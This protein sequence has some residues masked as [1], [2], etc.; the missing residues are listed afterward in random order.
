[1]AIRTILVQLDDGKAAPARVDVAAMLA[2][3]H[4]ARLTGLCVVEEPLVASGAI[5]LVPPAALA[6]ARRGASDRAREAIERLSEV[7]RCAGIEMAC[8]T[9]TLV[10][11]N[12]AAVFAAHARY[13]DLVVL[14][15][16]DPERPPQGGPGFPEHV[17]LACGRPVLMVPYIG[18]R[19]TLGKRAMIAWNAGREAARAVHDA[20]PLLAGAEIVH[21]LMVEPHAGLAEHGEEPGVDL[22]RHLVRHGLEVAVHRLSGVDVDVSDLILSQVADRDVDLLVMGAYGHSRAREFILGG[23]TRG[24]LQSMTVPVLMSH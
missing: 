24:I 17:L 23:A 22:A 10:R 21:I 15:Q 16:A 8:S 9:E 7:A 20:L 3:K 1:M 5:G 13:A 6:A 11:E 12:I 2:R 4:G 14:G 18:P 19:P